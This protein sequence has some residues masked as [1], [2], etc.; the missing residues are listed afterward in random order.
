MLLISP[1]MAPGLRSLHRGWLWSQLRSFSGNSDE[2]TQRAPQHL[3]L[4]KDLRSTS[5]VSLRGSTSAPPLPHCLKRLMH[6]GLYGPSRTLLT[7]LYSLLG[8]MSTMSSGADPR[9]RPRPCSSTHRLAFTRSTPSRNSRSIS[10]CC[11]QHC[12]NCNVFQ[13]IRLCKCL[14]YRSLSFAIWAARFFSGSQRPGS[15][16]CASLHEAASLSERLVSTTSSMVPW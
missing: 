8:P 16:P 14:A 12:S 6:G 4:T 9:R 15:E 7:K 3:R 13:S 5:S 1:F 10:R 2:Y 11:L